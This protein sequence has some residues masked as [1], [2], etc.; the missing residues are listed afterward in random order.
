MPLSLRRVG[1]DAN[2]KQPADGYECAF[3]NFEHIRLLGRE[4]TDE[5]AAHLCGNVAQQTARHGNLT[6]L[7][8][9]RRQQ[10]GEVALRALALH[11]TIYVQLDRALSDLRSVRGLSGITSPDGAV[12]ARGVAVA[13]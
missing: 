5:R 6:F 13:D 3:R 1:L 12:V 11:Q 8:V 7:L 10:R 9:I 2:W 4:Q